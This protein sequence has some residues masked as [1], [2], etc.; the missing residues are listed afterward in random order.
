MCYTN[1]IATAIGGIKQ[2][3]GGSSISVTPMHG[4][5][6]FQKKPKSLDQD[7]KNLTISISL[8]VFS[9]EQT[10]AFHIKQYNF[11]DIK[12]FFNVIC[13]FFLIII[14][15]ILFFNFYFKTTFLCTVAEHKSTRK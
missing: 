2:L 15:I 9:M 13:T 14:I 1:K 3:G 4:S 10:N 11:P 7:D 8:N 6:I 5:D 12:I